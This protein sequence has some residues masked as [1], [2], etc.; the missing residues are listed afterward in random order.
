MLL[1]F[2]GELM[3]PFW[4]AA[5]TLLALAERNPPNGDRVARLGGAGL[6]GI[7]RDWFLLPN[8]RKPR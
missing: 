5:A 8:C 4:L 6:T 3:N 1:P 7:N 2:I